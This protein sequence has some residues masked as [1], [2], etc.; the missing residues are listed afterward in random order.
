MQKFRATSYLRLSRSDDK[1]NESDSITNQRRLIED[2][3]SCN[4]DIEIVSER[5][6]DG[7]SGVIFDRPAFK[8]MMDDISQ[9]KI[10]CVIVKDLSRLGR[11]YIEMGHYLRRVL[12]SYGVRF[13]A[14]TDGIDTLKESDSDEMT[15][16]IKN[17]MNDAYS[18]DISTKTR[19]SLFSKRENG[20]YIGASAIY[21]YRKDSENKN[22]LIIDEYTSKVV[23]DI[24]RMKMEGMSA[25]AI[26]DALNSI[27]VLSPLE[28]KKNKGLPYSAGGFADKENVKWSATTIIRI[29]KDETYTG[30]LVQGKKTTFSYKLKN[31]IEKPQSEWIRIENA[32]EAIICKHDF[33][34]IQRI[35]HLDTR[36]SP[37]E[38][39]VYLFSGILI[40]G[41][42]GNRMTRKT[43]TYKEKKYYYYYC[44]TG[45]KNGCETSQMI[46]ESDLTN[47]V[48]ENIKSHIESVVSLEELWHSVNTEKI[49]KELVKKHTNQ[50][51]EN[52]AQLEQINTYK[53]S[54]Y[55]NFINNLLNKD[56]Y[57][58]LKDSYSEDIKRLKNAITKLEEEL[59]SVMNNSDERLQWIKH[60]KRFGNLQ[61]INRKAVIQLV[62]NIIIK[63]KGELQITFNYQPE[64]EKAMKKFTKTEI[65]R[66]V[67]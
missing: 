49:N 30:T 15:I 20:E 45:K 35:I 5:A 46:K 41:C 11:D 57:K 13:I 62:K 12:P 18:R 43:N 6:D 10:N 29:L 37:N 1:E 21:G 17:I 19:S 58:K 55:E 26:A 24:F 8:D 61:E 44:P 9:G 34:L 56:E 66:K 31:I 48:F 67:I 16:S 32:H 2:F 3:V 22:Q 40:C 63:S 60:F 52:K 27:G 39:S 51:A 50:M 65:E 54:L 59:E 7:Y 14:I 53:S 25:S 47:C 28:Y 4:L 64:Y 38:N 36:T 33:E 42:C 23:Q